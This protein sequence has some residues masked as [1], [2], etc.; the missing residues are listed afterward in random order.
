MNADNLGKQL[1]ESSDG[2]LPQRRWV[3]GLSLFSIASMTGIALYQFG[4]LKHT[5]E[6][7]AG[8]FDAEKVNG[9]G[10][11][12]EILE[13]PDAMLGIAS[14]SATLC[15]AGI[16]GADRAKTKP[17][18]PLLLAAKAFGD[19]AFA[20]KLA[21]DEATKYKKYCAWCLATALSSFA[22]AALA[23]PEAKAALA[24]LRK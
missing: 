20:A 13:T 24:E 10:Q 8:P 18:L 3:V 12:Y 7:K 16:A 5:L 4:I 6:P 23:V 15:L 17:L 21:T 9:S 22:C 2:Y 1:R 19:A 14:Y 11:A